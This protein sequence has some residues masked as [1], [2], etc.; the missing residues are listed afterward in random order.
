MI[1]AAERCELRNCVQFQ[2]EAVFLNARGMP[3]GA[4]LTVDN[5]VI[6][7]HYAVIVSDSATVTT[8]AALERSAR[9]AA[10]VPD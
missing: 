2:A 4:E 8:W 1:R 6:K 3:D 5:C 7:G 9:P 10:S